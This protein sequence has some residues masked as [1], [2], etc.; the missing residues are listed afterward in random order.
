MG[1]NIASWINES[2][3]SKICRK[4]KKGS[5][6]VLEKRRTKQKWFF[7][8]YKIYGANYVLDTHLDAGALGLTKKHQMK[9][10]IAILYAADLLLP[11]ADIPLGLF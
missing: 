10:D 1:M 3:R 8:A 7:N 6:V 4:Q 11:H 2:D 5:K 9:P